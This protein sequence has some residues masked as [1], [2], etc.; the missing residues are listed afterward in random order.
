MAPRLAVWTCYIPA[1]LPVK[2][3]LG[4]LIYG[5]I[6]F[7]CCKIRETLIGFLFFF[8]F[9]W[10]TIMVTHFQIFI[11]QIFWIN[12]LRLTKL[13][14]C[15]YWASEIFPLWWH[16][17]VSA[18]LIEKALQTKKKKKK[19]YCKISQK[20]I[21]KQRSPLVNE[22]SYL[23]FNMSVSKFVNVFAS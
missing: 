8:F 22:E 5:L 19:C 9:S 10:K 17:L 14:Q 11:D 18:T 12:N 13:G 3:F 21:R 20:Q 6:G 16:Y 4:I 23:D 15:S 7:I 2:L 1:K